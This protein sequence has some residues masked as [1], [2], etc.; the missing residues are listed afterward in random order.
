MEKSFAVSWIS[1]K[2]H[3]GISVDASY[4]TPGS[5]TLTWWERHPNGDIQKWGN[6]NQT[7]MTLKQGNLGIGTIFPDAKLAVKG[8]I[9]SQEVKVD[10][11]GS[12]VPDYVFSNNYQLP[13]LTEVKTYIDQH[14][15]LPEVPSAKEME[16]NGVNLGEMNMLLLKKIEELTL[17]VIELKREMNDLKSIKN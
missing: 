5:T 7:Y 8:T 2:I 16:A 1:A 10:M 9:H 14:K 3:D 6:A 15:H 13:T 4:G 11:L 17:Y 12:M